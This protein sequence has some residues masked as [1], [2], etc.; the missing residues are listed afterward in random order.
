MMELN[1]SNM[2]DTMKEEQDDFF[3]KA[4]YPLLEIAQLP[5]DV[6]LFKAGDRVSKNDPILKVHIMRWED[7]HGYG[8]LE[9]VV[10]VWL[11]SNKLKQRIG[12]YKNKE[13]MTL[14]SM[15]KLREEAYIKS[16]F[17]ALTPLMTDLLENLSEPPADED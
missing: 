11:Y 1:E 5:I 6:Q 17:T 15:E 10:E 16:M 4:I 3:R 13:L 12:I 9:T 7:P 8:E 2:A 14:G